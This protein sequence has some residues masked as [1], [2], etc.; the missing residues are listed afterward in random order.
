M[1]LNIKQLDGGI[2]KEEANNDLY[3]L[4]GLFCDLSKEI[5]DC[6]K[7]ML[8][9]AKSAYVQKQKGEE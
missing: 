7:A 3:L 4:A 5:M 6:K 8:G 9:K 2:T 1:E